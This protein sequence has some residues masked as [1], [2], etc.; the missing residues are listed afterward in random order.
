MKIDKNARESSKLETHFLF[1]FFWTEKGRLSPLFITA[2]EPSGEGVC[3]K[4]KKGVTRA[5]F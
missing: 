5:E 2:E 1:L 3:V 4:V